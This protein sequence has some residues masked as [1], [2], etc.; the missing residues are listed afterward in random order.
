L[1]L[2]WITAH[3]RL[4]VSSDW[5]DCYHRQAIGSDGPDGDRAREVPV[6]P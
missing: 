1:Y 3:Y 6:P 5:W 2:G 4:E